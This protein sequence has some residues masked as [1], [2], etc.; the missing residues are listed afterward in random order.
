VH[1]ME[2]KRPGAAEDGEQ[3]RAVARWTENGHD[4]QER[5]VGVWIEIL[6]W[7]TQ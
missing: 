5:P 4:V 6:D 2:A 3:L 1:E 7:R